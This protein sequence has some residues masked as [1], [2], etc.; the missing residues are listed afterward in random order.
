M[1]A[2]FRVLHDD[3][4]DASFTQGIIHKNIVIAVSSVFDHTGFETTGVNL[5]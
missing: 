4:K 5:T 3:L 2:M 1:Q